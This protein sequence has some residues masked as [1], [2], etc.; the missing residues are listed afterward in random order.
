MK[1]LTIEFDSL[2]EFFAL[3]AI[4]LDKLLLKQTEKEELVMK[5]RHVGSNIVGEKPN[6]VMGAKLTR[7]GVQCE[8]FYCIKQAFIDGRS[9][10]VREINERKYPFS[11]GLAL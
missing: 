5:R 9:S 8:G 3:D 1:Q 10:K 2:S 4:D 11:C 6:F 7:N